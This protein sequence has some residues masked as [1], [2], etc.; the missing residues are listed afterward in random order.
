MN[1]EFLLNHTNTQIHKI[2]ESEGHLNKSSLSE[3]KNGWETFFI[4][5]TSQLDLMFEPVISFYL[6][7]ISIRIQLN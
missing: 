4:V 6:P 1:L 5:A 2:S 7:V 3:K